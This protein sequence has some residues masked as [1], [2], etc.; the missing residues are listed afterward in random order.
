[1]TP[2][3][4][5][6]L[7]KQFLVDRKV[8]WR[9]CKTLRWITYTYS[10]QFAMNFWISTYWASAEDLQFYNN[11]LSKKMTIFILLFSG[12]I[13][14][15]VISDHHSYR[16]YVCSK[17][18]TFIIYILPNPEKVFIYNFDISLIRTL[19]YSENLYQK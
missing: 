1:M 12:E 6:N 17:S 8:I 14:Q 13:F 9:Q 4:S 19:E 16:I 10:D 18:F 15:S 7:K 3:V 5:S 2:A 11:L